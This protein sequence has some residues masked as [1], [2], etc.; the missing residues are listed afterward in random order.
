MSSTR[1]ISWTAAM[2]ELAAD[3]TK[4]T[5]I[6]EEPLRTAIRG[7]YRLTAW[8]GHSGK[9]Y[10]VTILPLT[11]EDAVETTAGV[12]LAVRRDASGV[13]ALI[14]VRS[15]PQ[16]DPGFLGWLAA[17]CQRGATELHVHM[18]A[19]GEAGRAAVVADLSITS[20]RPPASAALG[21]VA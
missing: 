19:D 7:F 6:R 2:H 11:R 9:R 4:R 10:V 21:R 18:L 15:C 5:S 14:A 3:R 13:A 17:C 12:A 20:P 1:K 16:S 8:R